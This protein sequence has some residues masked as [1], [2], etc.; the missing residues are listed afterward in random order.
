[1]SSSYSPLVS[2]IYKSRNIILELLKKR[3]FN[4]EDYT[5]FSINEVHIMYNNKQLDMLLENPDS[6]KK[7]Y[8]KYHLATRLGNSHVYDYIDD[9]FDI[10]DVLSDDDDLI[11]VSKDK[12]NATMKNLL[13]EL[14]IK[15]NKFVTIYN[16][17]D[18]LF[19]I[20][21]HDMVPEHTILSRE[22]TD[23]IIKKYNI[24]KMKEFPEI[25]RFDKVAMAIGLRPSH[26][27]KIVRSSPTSI[28]GLYY[29]MCY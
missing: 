25:S 27:C 16:L 2:K 24:N 4:V 29:R 13:E 1:M 21:N 17:H 14:Y 11:I 22:E 6:G 9:L 12:M 23:D 26:V 20:L 15:D 8:I 28:T 5:E 7:I 3:G 19:N 18:Y 10:E